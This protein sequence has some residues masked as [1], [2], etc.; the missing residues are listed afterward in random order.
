MNFAVSRHL[1][2][3]IESTEARLT[4]K[5]NFINEYF[6]FNLPTKCWK[7]ADFSVNRMKYLNVQ[8][9]LENYVSTLE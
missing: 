8:R 3:G 5:I 6:N 2:L 4:Q 7:T 1:S 9:L